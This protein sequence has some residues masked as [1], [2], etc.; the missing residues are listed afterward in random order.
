MKTW[1]RSLGLAR[2]V[3]MAK[4]LGEMLGMVAR[5]PLLRL[6]GSGQKRTAV[7]TSR[8]SCRKHLAQGD[9]AAVRAYER[10]HVAAE[11]TAARQQRRGAAGH[12][13]RCGDGPAEREAE[14]EA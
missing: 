2:A 9:E 7:S 14:D 5:K 11:D 8:P 12:S 6:N 3:L 13:G 1:T 4:A 10:V